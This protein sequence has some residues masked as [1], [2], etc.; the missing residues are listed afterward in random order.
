MENQIVTPPVPQGTTNFAENNVRRPVMSVKDWLIT[1]IL[2]IIPLANIILLFIWAF[3]DDTNK[4]RSNWAKAT[5]IMMAITIA[6]YVFF[7]AIFGAALIAGLT[8][9]G[10]GR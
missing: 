2:M 4:T 5:L 3:G 10:F 1:L 6:F 8:G 7:F 9:G